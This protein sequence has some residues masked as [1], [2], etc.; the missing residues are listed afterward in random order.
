MNEFGARWA[1]AGG[2]AIDLF[3]GFPTRP[4][5]DV[6]I[7]VL[8][9][10]QHRLRARLEGALVS[11]VAARRLSPWGSE[12]L[13]VSPVHE[14]HARWTDGA[15]LEFLLNEDDPVSAEWV[16]RRDARIR[17]SLDDTFHHNGEFPYLA[18]EVVLLYKSKAP[19]PKDEADFTSVRPRLTSEQCKWLREAIASL[20]PAHRWVEILVQE[21]YDR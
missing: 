8:R 7:A 12:E 20:S 17:R 18:P 13:L 4:H 5:A 2:W 11:K 19:G 16:Y 9:R 14:V 21:P 6:D 10:D 15:H 3:L 1:I